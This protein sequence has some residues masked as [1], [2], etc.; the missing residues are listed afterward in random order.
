MHLNSTSVFSLRHG[1]ALT[2]TLPL[3]DSH[4]SN[5]ATRKSVMLIL[6]PEVE[7]NEETI[8]QGGE[9]GLGRTDYP[10]PPSCWARPVLKVGLGSHILPQKQSP[11]D[12]RCSDWRL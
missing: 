7:E 8:G 3:G 6:L 12:N 4:K 1:V 2:L 5:Q 11:Y 9:S 10:A